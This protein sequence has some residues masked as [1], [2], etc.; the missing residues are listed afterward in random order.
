MQVGF[1]HSLIRPEEKKL[2]Q[3]FRAHPDVDLLLLD[4]R[5]M[6]FD[7]HAIESSP[8]VVLNR[9]I[10]QTRAL[11]AIR[12]LE[13]FGI[14]CINSSDTVNIC[15]DKLLTSLTLR[16]HKLPQPEVRVA[17]S[18][19]SALR[20]MEKMG[21]PVVLKPSVGSWGRLLSKINDPDAAAAILEHKK[22]LGSFHH[23]VYY[24]QKYIEKKGRDIRSI[25]I[26]DECVAAAYRTSEH[27]ITNAAR[28]GVSVLCPLTDEIVDLSLRAAKAVGG[29]LVGVDLF[30][31]ED[32]YLV[33]EVNHTL[34]FKSCSGVNGVDIPKRIVDFVLDPRSDRSPHK[35]Q[36][37]ITAEV[38]KNTKENQPGMHSAQQSCNQNGLNAKVAE[39]R[40]V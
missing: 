3:A 9:S 4:D 13:S 5:K 15:G 27:W 19:S 23:T 24:I 6:D 21:Y 1:L 33:N 36:D 37:L 29:G 11:N 10:N 25:V 22:I 7:L 20:A 34:E 40:R 2:L 26:G 39:N 38:Q 18:E 30:E 35:T 28:G 32:G 31:T 16:K 12:L 14:P 17:F 8:D